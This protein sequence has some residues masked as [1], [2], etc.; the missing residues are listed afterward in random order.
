MP[1]PHNIRVEND[2]GVRKVRVSMPR[3]AFKKLTAE[4][5]TELRDDLAAYLDKPARVVFDLS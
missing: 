4:E 5:L 2:Q 3:E 1:I